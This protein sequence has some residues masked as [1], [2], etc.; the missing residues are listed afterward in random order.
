MT[1]TTVLAVPYHLDERLAGFA[2]GAPVDRVVT[3]DDLLT[4]DLADA[5]P[6]QRMAA[7]YDCVAAAVGEARAD[8]AVPVVVSGDCTTSLGVI[9]GLQRSGLDPAIV[10]FDAHA[11]L[12]T[13]ATTASGYLGGMPLALAAGVGQLTLPAALGLRPVAQDRI[14]LVDARDTD[15]PEAELLARSPIRRCPV[16]AVRADDVPPGAVYLHLDVDVVDPAEVPGLLYP[17]AG[18]PSLVE[19]VEAVRRVVATGRVVAVGLG[20]TWHH[21]E[22]DAGAPSATADDGR[23]RV[24]AALLDAVRLPS[25]AAV[26]PGALPGQ[27]GELP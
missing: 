7:L 10:W 14:V 19:V 11:D 16:H 12:Q 15:P 21:G 8:G 20:A 24:A 13:E 6:W 25:A 5:G 22:A 4:A 26:V 17:T 23:A 3:A 18:G 27:P 1:P 9:A 2:S